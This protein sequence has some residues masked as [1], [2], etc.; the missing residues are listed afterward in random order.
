MGFEEA[1]GMTFVVADGVSEDFSGLAGQYSIQAGAGST[2]IGNADGV[3][4]RVTEAG[5]TFAGGAGDDTI[6]LTANQMAELGAIPLAS[7]SYAGGLGADTLH[8]EVYGTIDLSQVT[9]SGIER[10]T[11]IYGQTEVSLTIDQLL[12]LTRVD[13]IKTVVIVG[14]GAI[15]LAELAARNVTQW[16]MGDD[17]PYTITGTDSADTL[18]VQDANYVASLGAGDDVFEIAG[19]Y[20]SNNTNSLDGGAGTDTLRILSGDVDLSGVTLTD[21]ELIVVSSSSLAMTDQQWQDFGGIVTRT[22]G[23]TTQFILSLTAAGEYAMEVDSP[24]L[25]LSGSAG[26]DRLIGNINDDVLSGG[27]GNDYL[28]GGDGNDRLVAGAGIDTLMGGAGND[29]L[30]VTGKVNPIDTLDGGAGTD[31]LVVSD[32]QDLS[33]ANLSDIEVIK[34]A[35]VIYMT[36]AQVIAVS[37]LNGVVVELTDAVDSLV[38]NPNLRLTNGASVRLASFDSEYAGAGIVGTAS[39]DDITGS[40]NSDMLYGGRG[41]DTLDGA[42]GNDELY[43][44]RGSDTL[45]GGAGDDRMYFGGEAFINESNLSGDK[46]FGG[47]GNDTLVIDFEGNSRSWGT[48]NILAGSVSSVESL[49]LLDLHYSQLRITADIWQGFDS[50]SASNY[51]SNDVWSSL[52]LQ[53]QGE[54]GDVDFSNVS[55]ESFIYQI[56]LSGQFDLIDLSNNPTVWQDPSFS[57]DDNYIYVSATFTSLVGS[58]ERDRV[59]INATGDFAIELGAGDDT[60]RVN[61]AFTGSID[62]GEGSD[63]VDV[64][65]AGLTDFTN[66]AL[67]N[68]ESIYHGGS[69][70]IVTA[71]QRDAISF[72]G[73]G[74]VYVLENGVVTGTDEADSY[75]G[76]GF[77]VFEGG[78]GNDSIFNI[79]TAV[80]TGNQAD[81]DWDRNGSSLTIQHSRGTL[82]DGTDTLNGVMEMRFADSVVVL[83][84]APDQV[85]RYIDPWTM[86]DASE[87]R[88]N[89]NVL[90]YGKRESY[91]HDFNG[92]NDVFTMTLVP[93]SPLYVDGSTANG[94]AIYFQMWDAKTGLRIHFK[95]PAYGWI[96]GEYR[97]DGVG[98]ALLPV[99]NINNEWVPYEGGEVVVR[100]GTYSDVVEDYAFTINYQDDYAG[101]VDTLGQMDPQDGVI[102]GYIGDIG[103]SDWIRTELIA[104]TKYEFSLAGLSSGGGTLVDP[105]LELRDDQGRLIEN[106]IDII[107]DVAGTDDTIVFRPTVTGTYY[108]AVSDIIGQSKGSWTLTQGSLDTIAGNVSTTERAEFDQA[109]RFTIESEINQLSDHDW[110]KVWLDKGVTYRFTMDGTSLG[111]TLDDPQLSIRSVTGRL[112]SQDDNGGT[113][114]NAELYFSAP[115]SGWYYL[116]AGASGNGSKGTYILQGSSVQDDY[117][118]TILT[119]GTIGVDVTERGIVSYLGDS[120]WFKAGLSAG[121]TY[122]ITLEGDISEFAELDPLTDPLLIIRDEQGRIIQRVD[123]FDGTLNATAF[124]RA[125]AA[126]V[127][128][129]EVRS[130]FKYDIGSY[131]LNLSLAPPDDHGSLLDDTATAIAIDANFSVSQQGIIGIPGDKDVFAI[132]LEA[133]KVYLLSAEGMAGSAGTLANPLLRLFS[134]SG[135]LVDYNDNG[136][137]GNDAEFYF[138]PTETGV[139]FLQVS[140][141]DRDA[142][143]SFTLSVAERNRPSD[144]V[145]SDISTDVVL[146]PGQSF[147]GELLLQNDQ[148]WFAIDLQAGESYVFRALA[149]RSGNGSLEDPVL[150]L[151][152][153]TGAVVRLVDNMLVG[154]EPAFE[155]TP[156]ASGRYY[157]VVRAADGQTDTGSY[158]LSTRAPDDHGNTQADATIVGL[159]EV[160]AGGVQYNDGEFGVRAMDSV[161]LATDFDEDWFAFEGVA[162]QV[163]SFNVEI[164]PGSTLSRPVVEVVDAQGRVL[165]VGDGLETDN[166]LAAAAF[167][168]PTTGTYYAR[169]IDGAGA[170]GDYIATLTLGDASDEDSNGPVSLVFSS[171]GEITQASQTAVIGLTGDTDTYEVSLQAGHSYRVE[172]VA[173]RDGSTAPL[174][175]ATLDMI[176]TPTGAGRQ[177]DGLSQTIV[178][179]GDGSFTLELRV[180]EAVRSDW[181]QGLDSFDVAISY[182][183]AVFGQVLEADVLAADGSI[184]ATNVE[185]D[186]SISVS[187]FFYPEKFDVLADQPLVSIT[188]RAPSGDLSAASVSIDDVIF[189]TTTIEPISQETSPSFFDEGFITADADGLLSIT[190][191]PLEVTQTGQYR[192]RIIDLGTEQADDYID[193]VADHDVANGVLA[194][195]ENAAG[196]IDASGDVDLF[197]V[198]LTAGNIYDFSVKS[199]LDGLGSLAQAQLRI[200]NAEGQ[201]VSVGTYDG[202]T[203]RTELSIAVF[204]DGRYFLEVSAVDVVGNIGT[205]TL[206][207]RLRG[208]SADIQDDY[209]DNT[210]SSAIVGPG[211]PLSGEIETPG[212]R[213][214][215]RVT[216]E[217]GKVYVL[218]AL[219]DGDG[220]GGTLTDAV[221]RLYDADGNEIAYDDNTGAGL[222]AHIQFTPSVSGDY[223]LDVSGRGAAVGTYTLRVR[224]LYSGVAD[225][226]ASAQWYIDQVGITELDGQYTGAGVTV[227]VIDDGIDMSH[228]DLQENMNF[229]LSYDTQFNTQNGNPKYAPLIGL[230]PDDHGTLVA[231]IIGAVQNN[232]TGIVGASPDVD[233]VSTRVKWSWGQITEALSLQWQFDISNN[234]WGAINPFADNFNS[235]AL[236][237]AW[238]SIRK[239]VEEGRNGLGTVFVFSAGNSAAAGDNTNYHNFQNAREVITVGAANQDGT[240]AAFSTPGA[241]VLVSTYGVGMITTDRHQP[242]WGVTGGDYAPSFSGTSASAPLVSGV[243][244]LMLEANPDLGYRDVQ[245]ILAYSATHPEGQDWKQN[246]ASNLNLGGL[247]F[248]DKA[249]FGLVDA[250]AAVQLASTWTETDTAINEVYAGARQYGL[251]DAIP[252]GSGE[253]YTMTFDIDAN[254][255][256]EHIELGIDLRHERIGDLVITITSPDGTTST[257]MNRPT[258]TDER[259]FGLSGQDSGVPTHL[260]WDFSSVQFWGE[261]ASGTWTVTI[262]D[263]RAEQTGTVQSLSLRVYGER[264]DGNDTYVFTDEGF[265]AQTEAVLE[266]ESG[267]DTIN[268]SPVRYD[269]YIDLSEGIIAANT[270]TYGIADWTVVENAIS[271]RENDRLVGNEADNT[272]NAGDGNDVLEGRAGNDTLMGGGGQDTAVYS[273]ARA[274][275]TVSWN[276]ETDTITVVDNK[277]SNGDEGIDTLTG[278]E[279]LVFS[280]AEMTLGEMVGNTPPVANTTFFDAPVYLNAGVGIDYQLPDNAFTDTDGDSGD[281]TIEVTDAAGGELPEWLTYDETTGTFVGVPP[282]DYQGQLKLEVTAIDEFGESTSEILTLQFGDNQAPIVDDPSELVV[283]EDSGLTLIGLSAPVDP[284]ATDVLVTILD[285]PS[286]GQIIDKSGNPVA[287]GSVL[288]ADEFSELHYQTSSDANGDAGYLRYQAADADG[289]VA[290]SSVHIFVDA[291]N[292]APRFVTESGSLVINYPEQTEVTLDLLTPSDP[293]SELTTVTIIGLPELGS[294]S[295]DGAPVSLDQVL[296]FDQL[297]RLV[298]N[299][300]ENVNGP[301]GAVTIQ[302]VDPEGA[303]TNWSLNLEVQGDSASTSGTAGNDDLYGSTLDDV[304]YGN[305]GDD[306]IAGNAGNDRL[307]GGLGNDTLLG[308]RGDDQLDGSAG[309][310][311]LDGG[312]GN[313]VMAGGPGHDTYIVDD[314]GDIVL[315]V[316]GGGAGGDDLIVTSLT[317]SAPENVESLQAAAGAVINLTGNVLDNN[318]VGNDEANTLMGGSGRDNLVGK[319]G[320]DVLDGGAGVD[321]M[322]GG[323]GDD[324]YYVDA[325]ADRVLENANAGM[326]SV[327]ASSSYTLPSNV[328]NLTL[329]EGGDY[330]AGG[331]SLDN[332]LVGN[333]GNNV[334]AGGVGA[335]ILEGGLGDDTYILSDYLDTIIDTGGIDTIRSAL[336]V[337]LP[338]GIENAQLVGVAN[339][340]AIGNGADNQLTGNMAD[341]ILDGGAGVDTLIGGEGDDQFI[342]SSN[343]AGVAVDVVTDF[344]AGSDLLVIDLASFGLSP[345]ALGLLS[346]GLVSADSFVMGAGAVALDANDFFIYDTATGILKFD[347]DGNGEGEAIEIGKIQLDE[348]S[349]PL[350]SGDVFVAI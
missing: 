97:T 94:N 139:Y 127:Y 95:H 45:I 138:A 110:F 214:W 284:E 246:G 212:D 59:E 69:S 65:N 70:V 22:E 301:I 216:L 131:A 35:G 113:G 163:L 51:Y 280:D 6:R 147:D 33:N 235:T 82:L 349:G 239:G 191:A 93:N 159:G 3:E 114:T 329:T 294:V 195:N 307:L 153:D 193:F 23:A 276:P 343:G 49:S 107:T 84:D 261:Q 185:T 300:N 206:D 72:D 8:L 24:F 43:G 11:G 319:G 111:G 81:Y 34:G 327:I 324:V 251:V 78:A 184:A 204:E 74:R 218:D 21:I 340:V 137:L 164:A 157:L 160:V 305:G 54:G 10:L 270:V 52:R 196:K 63:T 182:D 342:L 256:V 145:P 39:N 264:D 118:N 41:S 76:N 177:I 215:A 209:A 348:D 154:N 265:Q 165:A 263:V 213:D 344:Q 67:T 119:E 61:R 273:G 339:T 291:D 132:T 99:V 345:E 314:A 115:D 140:S 236:T 202:A 237:F 266:D 325:K 186:G 277:A 169:V 77:G 242:G 149:S 299:L 96:D 125:P 318:I 141:A 326:D 12:G 245:E 188:F 1:Y 220:A 31:T 295:L 323:D 44:G 101:S 190:V 174:P 258:V 244:A 120:D 304:L 124:F 173:I 279:R 250:Y 181:A 288:T 112:L 179:N 178:D 225:P 197:A 167:F 5:A 56:Q 25:G 232:E 257:L 211:V 156:G 88:S 240:A 309:N 228:P 109:G 267:I 36:S 222:D 155:F 337:T 71:E 278:I 336:D 150:E 46:A 75:S 311:Y 293:E 166:G 18:N 328:E 350:T 98:G 268:A 168:V 335:D 226:L 243:V 223:Y 194:I 296:T 259:P 4:V 15:D 38:L 306:T 180:A 227:G 9:L 85:E 347:A 341:N 205:Y 253:S 331:N 269:T 262:T 126:G 60:L 121:V 62:G 321:A 183:D 302:A 282:E 20:A 203:G 117:D 320:N 68:I 27:A 283:N 30:D 175:S 66:I 130:A 272:L 151:R 102:Q 221:L 123:D 2:I 57:S 135:R 315:E 104:G 313:D 161:G 64:R 146:I 122:V 217:A 79:T 162:G 129:F 255:S 58:A 108:L 322:A 207:T 172:T 53:I 17:Q 247:S 83:D 333:S 116:D 252:D 133:G 134:T 200:L 292:D 86:G 136:G 285:L 89:L 192:L 230:P 48:Y 42:G 91:K 187:A 281:L 334:L 234:S 28:D 143:G 241:S 330:T 13:N 332:H 144:D 50:V 55:A 260:L 92:D 338:D 7:G 29:I 176:Y 158:V 128:F 316:I 298:F 289:V 229:A 290:E 297:N 148:D 249:G 47:E 171:Q 80:F 87:A 238:V 170:E 40:N 303:A 346:S 312:A 275:Y 271:G 16:R 103:D 274:E 37:E 201:L 73:S 32:G 287:V 198:N 100:V 14:G 233:L 317:M 142:M 152:D 224:E 26:A 254:M 106:G 19:S 248:N 105:K 208:S 210:L 90:E 310:D 189:D 308:G 231:G 219:A 286:L 199:Y